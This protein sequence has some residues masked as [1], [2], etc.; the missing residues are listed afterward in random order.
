MNELNV[1]WTVECS[2]YEMVI[3][4]I[5]TFPR[6]NVNAIQIFLLDNHWFLNIK[7]LM[8]NYIHNFDINK[9]IFFFDKGI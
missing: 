4:V 5:T 9:Y 3:F 6:L 2:V 7:K 8:Y 1:F